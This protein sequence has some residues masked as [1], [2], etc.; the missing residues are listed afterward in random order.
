MEVQPHTVL[1]AAEAERRFADLGIPTLI[2]D[3]GLTRH[4]LPRA[5]PF[6]T[7]AALFI[8]VMTIAEVSRNSYLFGGLF[9]AALVLWWA[10][11]A[12]SRHRSVRVTSFLLWISWPLVLPVVFALARLPVELRFTTPPPSLRD[13]GFTAKSSVS[14]ARTAETMAFYAGQWA[15]V[16]IVAVVVTWF[17]VLRLLGRGRTHLH[18]HAEGSLA[19]QARTL[20]AMALFIL[21]FFLNPDVWQVADGLT[22]FRMVLTLL[23]LIAVIL[24]AGAAEATDLRAELQRD[25]PDPPPPLLLSQQLNLA[26]ALGMRQIAR[27]AWVGAGVFAFLM[28]LGAITMPP[29]T[30]TDGSAP[31]LPPPHRRRRGAPWPRWRCC[32]PASPSCTSPS[33]RPPGRN[34]GRSWSP[35]SPPSST[36]RCG[37]TPR[38]SL[39]WEL[40]TPAGS[41]TSSA[42][43]PA[44]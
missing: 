23:L 1:T 17:G 43:S 28:V 40:R 31:A 26:L 34:T 3:Y 42:G 11:R 6:F 41:T 18:R 33:T 29:K 5:L 9:V 36:A 22:P 35:M 14:L 37:S 13:G 19:R 16:T 44:G 4:V 24:V 38:T 7:G 32:S 25:A 15:V 10:L 27:A 39:R 30:I 20:P 2:R 12:G 8:Y 21:F